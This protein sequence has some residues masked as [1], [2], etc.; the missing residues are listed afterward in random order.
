M[1]PLKPDHYQYP[2]STQGSPAILALTG[3]DPWAFEECKL[4]IK[5]AGLDYFRGAAV[6]YLWRCAKKGSY[7]EDLGKAL[8]HLHECDDSDRRIFATVQAIERRLE[9]DYGY[10]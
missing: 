5:A 3:L 10:S 1:N 8:Q 6:K 2:P 7:R 4:L 9:I